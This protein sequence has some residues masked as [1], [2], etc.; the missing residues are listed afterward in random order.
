M[1]VK[2]ESV[3]EYYQSLSETQQTGLSRIRQAILAEIPDAEELLSY[4]LP[5]FKRGGMLVYCSAY[6]DHYAVS[7]PPPFDLFEAFKAELTPY[8]LTK[9]AVKFPADEP[10]PLGLIVELVKYKDRENAEKAAKKKT[11]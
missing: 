1:A 2:F 9:T 6:K 7:F 8:E 3:E 4:Q 11:K 5:A 10:L